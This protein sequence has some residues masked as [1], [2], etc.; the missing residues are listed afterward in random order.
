M[1]DPPRAHLSF[2]SADEL[3]EWL[4]G[5][6]ETATE[7][8][9]RIFRKGTGHET[10]D[11][12]GC[13]VE[14]IAHGWIDGVKM[15]LDDVSYLQRLTP[16]KPRSNWSS[17]NRDHA[18]RLI[19]EG[20]M[21]AAGQRH[22]DAAKADGRWDSAYSGSAG[23]EIPQDFLDALDR[24]PAAKAFFATLDRRNLYRI[25]YQLQTAKRPETRARRLDRM[26]AQLSRGERFH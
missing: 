19:A 5:N 7:L 16:R 10:V 3:R 17:K 13:V 12:A 9:V 4:A 1:A 24:D 6:H 15:P 11:W 23:L 18:E 21:T 2:R 8:W 14:A 26:V 20:R 22:V 25:Y